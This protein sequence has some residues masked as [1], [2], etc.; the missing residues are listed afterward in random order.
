MFRTE[1]ELLSVMWPVATVVLISSSTQ[2]FVYLNWKML[3]KGH[4]L[5]DL[6]PFRNSVS[7]HYE[8]RVGP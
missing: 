2:T 5:W 3:A 8:F 4:S 7:R 1:T 6:Y